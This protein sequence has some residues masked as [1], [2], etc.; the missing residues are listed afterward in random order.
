MSDYNQIL[1]E[2]INYR[3]ENG[4][5]HSL[6]AKILQK[7]AAAGSA[8]IG[9]TG[10]LVHKIG[11]AGN[12]PDKVIN[13]AQVQFALR[14]SS[15]LLGKI[16][17]ADE[18]DFKLILHEDGDLLFH[19]YILLGTKK[20]EYF[21][22]V[23]KIKLKAYDGLNLL[24]SLSIEDFPEDY[25]K[26]DPMSVKSF[27][28][29]LEQQIGIE[30][31]WVVYT[32]WDDPA[33]EDHFPNGF[34]FKLG[35]LMRGVDDDERT[36]G[37]ALELFC[38]EHNFQ[39]FQLEGKWRLAGRYE[40]VKSPSAVWKMDI[41]AGTAAEVDM[42]GPV[43][44]ASNAKAYPQG[45]VLSPLAGIEEEILLGDDLIKN[46]RVDPNGPG[47]VPYWE[48]NDIWID[49]LRNTDRDGTDLQREVTRKVTFPGPNHVGYPDANIK[50]LG[51]SVLE[52]SVKGVKN[53]Q[54]G[55]LETQATSRAVVSI[56]ID[57]QV[58]TRGK[59]FRGTE[60]WVNLDLFKLAWVDPAGDLD[61]EVTDADEIVGVRYD[62]DGETTALGTK[63]ERGGD[64]W[65][66]TRLDQTTG[67]NNHYI[68]EVIN[69]SKSYDVALHYRGDGIQ[70][71]GDEDTIRRYLKAIIRPKASDDQQGGDGSKFWHVIIKSFSMKVK[72]GTGYH[73][74]TKTLRANAGKINTKRTMPLAG[75]SDRN[76]LFCYFWD[77]GGTPT[78]SAALNQDG[79]AFPYAAAFNRLAMQARE[80]Q[81]VRLDC[82][83]VEGVSPLQT[84]SFDYDDQKKAVQL[85]PLMYKRAILSGDVQIAGLEARWDDGDIDSTP[86]TISIDTLPPVVDHPPWADGQLLN[87]KAYFRRQ[88]GIVDDDISEIEKDTGDF[89]DYIDGAFKDDL[90]QRSEAKA[91]TQYLNQLAK[92]KKAIDDEYTQL[93]ANSGLTGT[94]KTNLEDAK[95]AY[96]SKYNDLIEAINDAIADGKAT[97]EETSAVNDA[98]DAFNNVVQTLSRRLTQAVNAI[99]QA[100]ADAA[101]SGAKGYTDE[102]L[103]DYVEATVYSQKVAAL[104]NQLDGQVESWFKKYDPTKQNA[105][106]AG[107]D[108]A[109]KERHLNDTF[110]NVWDGQGAGGSG[111]PGASWRWVEDGGSYQWQLI[112]DTATQQALQLAG[113]ARDTADGKRRVFTAQPTPP[114]DRGDL[115]SKN[116]NKDIFVC[117]NG[118]QSGSYNSSDWAKNADITSD[119]NSA[120]NTNHDGHKD[121]DKDP[122]WYRSHHPC[123]T[124]HEM[125][126]AGAV[127]LTVTGLTPYGNHITRVP[128]SSSDPVTQTHHNKRRQFY[129]TSNGNN[130]WNPWKEGF[131]EQRLPDFGNEIG[132][133][134]LPITDGRVGRGFDSS[135]N[136]ARNVP[137]TFVTRQAV[138]QH[139]GAIDA[140]ALANAPAE[141]GAEKTAGKS[142]ALLKNRTA[143]NM[144]FYHNLPVEGNASSKETLD[145]DAWTVDQGTLLA[146]RSHKLGFYLGRGSA[147]GDI[148]IAHQVIEIN[149]N[150]AADTLT[151]SW[152]QSSYQGQDEARM[153]MIYKDSS[154]AELDSRFASYKAV[155]PDGWTYRSI[156]LKVPSGTVKV[157]VY[158]YMK[159]VAG[160]DINGDIRNINLFDSDIRE[161]VQSWKPAE[162]G[163]VRHYGSL[164]GTK[165][166]IT[167]DHTAGQ[168]E[169]PLPRI[170]AGGHRAY[171]GLNSSGDVARNVP[172]TFVTRQAVTQHEGAIDALAL[173]NG[174]AQAGADVTDYGDRRVANDDKE[175]GVLSISRPKGAGYSS[176]GGSTGAIVITLPHGYTNTIMSFDIEVFQYSDNAS[177]RLHVDGYNYRGTHVWTRTSVNLVGDKSADNRVRFGYD[178]SKCCLVIGET[179]DNWSFLRVKVSNFEAHWHNATKGYWDDGWD[180]SLKTSL[181]GYTFD[182]D[183]SD[184]LVDANQ[185][186][187]TDKVAGHSAP[188]VADHAHK[189]ADAHNLIFNTNHYNHSREE[190]EGFTSRG[191][192]K[193]AEVTSGGARMVDRH[194]N[195]MHLNGE[196]SGDTEKKYGKGAFSPSLAKLSH[197]L[198]KLGNDSYNSGSKTGTLSGIHAYAGRVARMNVS[199]NLSASSYHKDNTINGPMGTAQSQITVTLEFLNSS[200]SVISGESYSKHK[201]VHSS[202]LTGEST[203]G[204][205]A[206][207]K[208][209]PKDAHKI[210][211]KYELSQSVNYGSTTGSI[212]FDSNPLE[213]IGTNNIVSPTKVRTAGRHDAHEFYLRAEDGAGSCILKM[214]NNNLGVYKS[215]GTFVTNIQSNVN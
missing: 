22:Q 56:S 46:S 130:G 113:E 205:I 96:D 80:L 39:V 100:K 64:C 169:Y 191:D 210:R 161:D 149:S 38:G 173:A 29:T 115:W 99:T 41:N 112:G 183:Y 15:N 177:F 58:I 120:G 165:P 32:N 114:Y 84:I 180:V 152:Y 157:Y 200:G 6:E 111:T 135:G 92:D 105:P 104:Q 17:G 125:K 42:S 186:R 190:I 82:R 203:S 142:L 194:G 49:D 209:T 26:E 69:I 179:S 214:K 124:R 89:Q 1:K 65:F 198:D 94:A 131:G 102:Q 132:N 158:M 148:T 91:I 133:V 108:A 33:S 7:G 54:T 208:T 98:F 36:W 121:D 95:D 16:G 21:Q 44:D 167:A 163:A 19:G 128:C 14:D 192:S 197:S 74:Q 159:L 68:Q 202:S 73:K 31:G 164:G 23:P 138:T 139:E 3:D 144:N 211:L 43:L 13:P 28:S 204:T 143:G 90:I 207:V 206:F 110:T 18:Q 20:H 35:H 147:K 127:G 212:R 78:K 129:R 136:V 188:T 117:I 141:A 50:Q 55:R 5:S 61:A 154:N 11:S 51:K 189:G 70:E 77:N 97:A 123:T 166:P 168:F 45:K 47:D 151:L 153:G 12:S 109:E 101:E 171:N 201:S 181:S 193:L 103:N 185:S 30:L 75:K 170:G 187:D 10:D 52:T 62:E 146:R 71:K 134:P 196:E 199:Y 174:P 176:T 81:Q 40:R 215:D 87:L 53:Q 60:K 175:D 72:A 150:Y 162:S 145:T 116:D 195:E 155:S 126:K 85:L 67:K 48:A 9:L 59:K 63:A 118:R 34:S 140:L 93:Y 66:R 2:T 172:K 182:K 160:R 86:P 119:N 79:A 106:A 122:D 76:G 156:S 37:K 107:W 83:H 25:S 213:L 88:I 57:A 4:S 24:N 178:G 137:K 8:P 27:L 184:A